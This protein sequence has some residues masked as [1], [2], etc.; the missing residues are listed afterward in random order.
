MQLPE[1]NRQTYSVVS[2]PRRCPR[3]P[4]CNLQ[5]RMLPRFPLHRQ[6]RRSTLLAPAAPPHRL[7]RG[8][9][10]ARHH[11]I[12]G[13][14]GAGTARACSGHYVVREARHAPTGAA[15]AAEAAAAGEWSHEGG[16]GTAPCT[17]LAPCTG[18][19][20][21]YCKR[22]FRPDYT[23]IMPEYGIRKKDLVCSACCQNAVG[24]EQTWPSVP[25]DH[26]L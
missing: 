25:S 15:G 11:R 14:W 12:P 20:L 4:G 5:Q 17:G 13:V 10:A 23:E 26:T 16:P 3:P 8:A 7:P 1:A 18:C 6:L 24:S 22:I 9:A 2:L 21:I 19:Y